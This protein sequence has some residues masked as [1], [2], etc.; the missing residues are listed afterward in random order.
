MACLFVRDDAGTFKVEAEPDFLQSLLAHG[1]AQPGLVSSVEHQE[2]SSTGADQLAAQGAVR[3]GAIVPLIDFCAAHARAALL[4]ALPVDIHQAAELGQLAVFQGLPAAKR[5]FL[6][7]VA[8]SGACLL[9]NASS[10]MKWRLSVI[11]VSARLLLSSC[12]F[13]IAD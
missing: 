10:F 9:R 1:V 8:F 7:G 3:H 12:S 2:P 4:L 13:R 5:Q 6:Y 11:S